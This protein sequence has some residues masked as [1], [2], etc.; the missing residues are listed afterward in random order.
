MYTIEQ[1]FE[2]K[3]VIRE[4]ARAITAADMEGQTEFSE[5]PEVSD[6][7]LSLIV[8][9]KGKKYRVTAVPA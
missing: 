4:L 9:L 2:V 3:E 5:W 1:A 6:S 8:T 7:S